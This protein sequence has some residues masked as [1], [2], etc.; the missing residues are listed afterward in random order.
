MRKLFDEEKK[1]RIEQE[2]AL[3]EQRDSQSETEEKGQHDAREI[4]KL[5]TMLSNLRNELDRAD[6]KVAS[7][8]AEI[9]S[10]KSESALKIS[11]LFTSVDEWCQN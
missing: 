9:M 10:L 8:D 1:R 5:E 11:G 4:E 2:A 6:A 7:Q 3:K